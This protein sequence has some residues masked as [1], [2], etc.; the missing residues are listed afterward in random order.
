MNV[1]LLKVCL[2]FIVNFM[3]ALGLVWFF[4][5]P[6][7]SIN[8]GGKKGLSIKLGKPSQKENGLSFEFN[9]I[10]QKLKDDEQ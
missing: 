1:A 7:F 9:K 3:L 8:I 5:Q 10:D 2:D 4:V 6:C